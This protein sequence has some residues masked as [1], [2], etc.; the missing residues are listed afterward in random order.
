M[1]RSLKTE[2]AIAAT[3]SMVRDGEK[4]VETV[5]GSNISLKWLA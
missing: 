3:A 2:I 1:A 5:F 4:A